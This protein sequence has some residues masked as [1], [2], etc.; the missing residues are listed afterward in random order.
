MKPNHYSAR[1]HPQT[2][3]VIKQHPSCRVASKAKQQCPCMQS[4]VSSARL[5]NNHHQPT[6]DKDQFVSSSRQPPH[7]SR[8]LVNTLKLNLT[9]THPNNSSAN[10]IPTLHCRNRKQ[11]HNKSA[12]DFPHKPST[13]HPKASHK[14][15]AS[16]PTNG[17]V[18]KEGDERYGRE[19]TR[20]KSH[21]EESDW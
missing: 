15:S 18:S 12:I 4:C 20:S 7:S 21:S 1:H 9:T 2:R 14:P 3:D 19:L 11:K 10:H 6:Q 13:E 5:L 17:I 8:L 16:A